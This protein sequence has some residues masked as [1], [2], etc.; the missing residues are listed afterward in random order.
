M[1]SWIKADHDFG[2]P[3]VRLVMS[4]RDG[5]AVR[6]LTTMK[7]I[8]LSQDIALYLEQEIPKLRPDLE[9][10]QVWGINCGERGKRFGM[11]TIDVNHPSLPRVSRFDL[12]KQQWLEPCTLC[13]KPI[14]VEDKQWSRLL[15]KQDNSPM[16]VTVCSEC[17]HK[18]LKSLP[19]TTTLREWMPGE[20]GWRVVKPLD[21][22]P[23][24]TTNST[25]LPNTEWLPKE[26]TVGE[27]QAEMDQRLPIKQQAIASCDI[28]MVLVPEPLLKEL[29]KTVEAC[30][31]FEERNK[32][33]SINQM[34]EQGQAFRCTRCNRPKLMRDMGR[35]G[36]VCK[37]C[38]G[39]K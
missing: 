10:C 36:G 28:P 24:G 29:S 14:H 5:A 37:T 31:Q 11:L 34:I 33:S 22:T 8:A 15:A 32:K 3:W 20:D 12:P 26:G 6:L 18:P 30:R 16:C 4:L 7:D 19:E 17:C 23:T 38:C 13:K 39:E 2:V 27:M 1:N 35:E 21:L 25:T 9:G